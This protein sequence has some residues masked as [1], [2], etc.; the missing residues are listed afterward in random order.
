MLSIE[1]PKLSYSQAFH[2]LVEINKTD[3]GRGALGTDWEDL[4]KLTEILTTKDNTITIDEY[5]TKE[6]DINRIF[7]Y[8]CQYNVFRTVEEFLKINII[9]CGIAGRVDILSKAIGLTLEY[10]SNEI[11]KLIMDIYQDKLPEVKLHMTSVLDGKCVN[12]CLL[13]ELVE[14]GV[15]FLDLNSKKHEL[16]KLITEHSFYY[17]S[18]NR[19]GEREMIYYILY[20]K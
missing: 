4:Q 15:T 13:N 8:A 3:L 12:V 16:I 2:N 7:C 17:F 9:K 18:R 14:S 1:S 10:E 6:S 5:K 11:L 19:V 20:K